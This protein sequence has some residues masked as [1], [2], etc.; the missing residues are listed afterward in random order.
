MLDKKAI[1]L[2]PAKF[3]SWLKWEVETTL[4]EQVNGAGTKIT[5]VEQAVAREAAKGLLE[6][7]SPLTQNDPPPQSVYLAKIKRNDPFL[8]NVFLKFRSN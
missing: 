7:P 3:A 2:S 6:E 8:V 1:D 5:Q 4:L